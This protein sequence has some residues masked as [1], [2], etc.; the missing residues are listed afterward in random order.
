MVLVFVA[1]T[2]LWRTANAQ[3]QARHSAG[4]P[5]SVRKLPLTKFYDTPTPLPSGK[6]GELIRSSAFDEYDLPSGVSAVRLLYHSRSGNGDDVAASG[7]V[8]FPDRKT[9]SGGW[10]VLAWAHDLTGVARP[11]AP[12]LTRNLQHGTFLSMYV[13]IGYAVVATDYTGLGSNFGNAFADTSS[14]ALDVIYS[15]PAAR[16]ALPQL[17]SRWIAMGT[18][19]GGATVVGVAELEHDI[20]DPN[21]LGSVT[22]SHLEDFEDIFEPVNKL[23]YSLPLFLAHGIKTVYPQF[24]INDV[25]TDKA[26][27]LYHQ[28][29]K[30][31]NE[32]AIVSDASASEML[33]PNWKSNRFVQDY[34]GRNRLGLKPALAP[35]LV[36]SSGSDPLITKTA[37]IISRLCQQGDQVEFE[38]YPEYDPGRVIGDSVRDQIAW[39][40]ARF[41]N[42]PAR[43]NCTVPH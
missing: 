26:I 25:L 32:T 39:I 43:S 5:E 6:P 36:V 38:T 11:C 29:G 23:S 4:H 8:L 19:E 27:P 37:K 1:A 9:S 35:L 13:N 2:C 18:G 31:C 14:N 42:R 10:P 15:I 20:Q 28:I 24:E 22:L 30:V 21:Y 16:R 41:T 3:R 40:E 33:K 17:G 34:F 12:S 7:V